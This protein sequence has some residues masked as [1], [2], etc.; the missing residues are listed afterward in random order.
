M[1]WVS[2]DNCFGYFFMIKS[3]LYINLLEKVRNHSVQ[4]TFHQKCE[5]IISV[6][7]TACIN[8]FLVF[9]V[10][11]YKKIVL[12]TLKRELK[13]Q[14]LTF[15]TIL[16]CQ[17][18]KMCEPAMQNCLTFLTLWLYVDFGSNDEGLYAL[19]NHTFCKTYFL[20]RPHSWSK[21][22]QDLGWVFRKRIILH[23]FSCCGSK[24]S[25]LQN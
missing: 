4:I 24:L 5:T 9:Q 17:N 6:L 1:T 14:S 16:I 11:H 15:Q 3:C 8:T 10:L 20:I 13:K 18:I 22:Y 25:W 12:E 7:F 2:P 21:M 19:N 23:S